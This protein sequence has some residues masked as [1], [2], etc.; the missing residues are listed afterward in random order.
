MQ[1]SKSNLIQFEYPLDVKCYSPPIDSKVV[2]DYELALNE[3]LPDKAVSISGP[4]IIEC[5]NIHI[6]Y[7][8]PELVFVFTRYALIHCPNLQT[9]SIV[10]NAISK[11][12]IYIGT[13]VKELQLRKD[14]F[15]T[16]KYGREDI[17]VFKSFYLIP[18]QATLDLLCTNLPNI[19]VLTCGT[20]FMYGRWT[21]KVTEIDLK[22]FKNLELFQFDDYNICGDD[23]DYIFIRLQV[24]NGDMAYYS[25]RSGKTV[26]YE[27]A[28]LQLFQKYQ[29]DATLNICLLTVKHN[30]GVKFI[31]SS[32]NHIIAAEF[33]HGHLLDHICIGNKFFS[34]AFQFSING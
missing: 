18:S 1:R 32:G 17:K 20:N 2:H 9:C 13:H 4:E 25:R 10:M 28:T 8:N 22:V 26:V 21:Q 23:T 11:K 31:V 6:G 16:S 5:L 33:D 12:T 14:R 3:Y 29:D 30:S 15:I 34:K 27:T 7:G 19:Q 24:N